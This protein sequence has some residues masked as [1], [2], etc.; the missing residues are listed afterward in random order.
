MIFESYEG[1][2]FYYALHSSWFLIYDCTLKQE[3][4]ITLLCDNQKYIKLGNNP[5]FHSKSEHIKI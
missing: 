1:V 3:Q 2:N 4:P 5:V